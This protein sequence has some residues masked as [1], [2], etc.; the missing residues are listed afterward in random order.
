MTCSW[1]SLAPSWDLSNSEKSG[2][3]WVSRFALASATRAWA[4]SLEATAIAVPPPWIS[5]GMFCVASVEV[6][7]P[8]WAGL[9]PV[10]SVL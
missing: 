2:W 7:L 10:S 3:F 4:V 9:R 8:V 1:K 5:Y 6:I